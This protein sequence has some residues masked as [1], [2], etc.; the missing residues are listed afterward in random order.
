VNRIV[1][2]HYLFQ[3]VVHLF[4]D[5]VMVQPFNVIF[6]NEIHISPICYDEVFKNIGRQIIVSIQ[7]K[8]FRC[9]CVVSL[10]RDHISHLQLNQN[11]VPF[12]RYVIVKA[13]FVRFVSL[14][15][16]SSVLSSPL[17]VLA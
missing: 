2:L 4:R 5:V 7:K 13:E 16:S 10:Q 6:M 8:K 11:D 17:S 14:S 15:F 12:K 1:F 3:I 9:L